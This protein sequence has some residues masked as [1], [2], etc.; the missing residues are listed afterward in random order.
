MLNSL[1]KYRTETGVML[2]MIAATVTVIIF[3]NVLGLVWFI[4]VPAAVLT[5]V[6]AF[7]VWVRYLDVHLGKRR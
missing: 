6:T 1:A 7:V 3:E 5:Y 2:G 4:S